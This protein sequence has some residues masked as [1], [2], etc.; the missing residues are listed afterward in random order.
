MWHLARGLQQDEALI[1]P[2]A[3]DA[4][5]EHVAGE[6]GEIEGRILAAE[7]ELEAALAV[8]VAVARA[9]IASGP[10]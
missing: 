4:A 7:G 10:R 8:E 2:V 6:G 9:G 1:R 5:S 3:I